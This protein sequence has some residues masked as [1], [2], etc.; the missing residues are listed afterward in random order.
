MTN[1]YRPLASFS[2]ATLIGVINRGKYA[3]YG[4]AF[5]SA[6]QAELAARRIA[7]RRAN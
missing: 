6:L 4:E 7:E 1:N 3:R 2:T 5:E